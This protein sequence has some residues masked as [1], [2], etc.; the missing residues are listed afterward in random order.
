MKPKRNHFKSYLAW[1]YA[2][3]RYTARKAQEAAASGE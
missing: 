2:V 3:R 1:W